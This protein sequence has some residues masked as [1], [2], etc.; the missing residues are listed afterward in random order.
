MLTNA[1]PASPSLFLILMCG[2][3]AVPFFLI[4]T[5]SYLKISVV[6]G[7]LRN[8]LG[9]QQVPSGTI[10][11]LLAMLLTVHIMRPVVLEVSTLASAR[12]KSLPKVQ[13]WTFS[14]LFSLY[15][16]SKAPLLAFLT[17]QSGSRER[18]FFA[19]GDELGEA[20]P[21]CPAD[22]PPGQADQCPFDR[23]NIFSL[24]PAFVLSQLREGFAFGFML[25]LPFLVIDLV[26]AHLLLGLGLTMVS[27]MTITLPLKILLFV[28]TDS[29]LKISSALIASYR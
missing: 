9:A 19:T 18:R 25:F 5:T 3:A 20:Q 4:G 26:V 28:S 24:I 21:V 2:L 11:S 27:P 22:W 16:A 1:F 13:Q 17:R 29:W 12:A 23:E 10:T 7:I 8:A 6:F 15:D 14:Q